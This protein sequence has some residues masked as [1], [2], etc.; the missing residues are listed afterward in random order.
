MEDPM[1]HSLLVA[2]FCFTV[3]A[4]SVRVID[5]DTFDADA[6]TWI[7]QT[8]RARVRLLL[9][10]TPERKGAT[11]EAGDRA[12]AYTAEWLS[13]GEVQ[14]KTCGHDSFGR[15]LGTVSRGSEDLGGL[16]LK[17]GLAVPFRR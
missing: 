8:T 17:E 11:R 7:N 15:V 1:R 9:V 14:I 2:L 3:S 10:N 4:T 6:V 16:L 13:R 12:R 5:G